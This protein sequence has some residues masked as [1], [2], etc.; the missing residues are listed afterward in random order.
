MGICIFLLQSKKNVENVKVVNAKIN[1]D[2][3]ARAL[4]N[5]SAIKLKINKKNLIVLFLNDK[6][7]S[8][9][10]IKSSEVTKEPISKGFGRHQ[11]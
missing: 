10:N 5:I 1:I 7:R 4:S 9:N 3:A 6:D 2:K 8:P 11:P